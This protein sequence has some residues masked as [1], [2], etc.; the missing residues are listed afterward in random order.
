MDQIAGTE[1]LI[2]IRTI[3]SPMNGWLRNVILELEMRMPWIRAYELKLC[4]RTVS[5]VLFTLVVK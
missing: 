5:L 2:F 1:R 3:S 4:S